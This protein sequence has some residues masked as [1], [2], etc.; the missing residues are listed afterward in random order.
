MIHKSLH[1]DRHSGLDPESSLFNWIP[2]G[3]SRVPITGGNHNTHYHCKE[4]LDPYLVGL[5]I[6]ETNL[7]VKQKRPKILLDNGF[8]S[9]Y[10][11]AG[12]FLGI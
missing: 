7:P 2:A 6:R 12:I 5:N 11:E 3:V 4:V 1:R 8:L 9:R 10:S